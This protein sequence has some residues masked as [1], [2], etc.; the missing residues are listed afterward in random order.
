MISISQAYIIGFVIGDGNLSKI[1]FLIRMYDRD[2]EYVNSILVPFFNKA[3]NKKPKT[4]Y[5]SHNR[6]YVVY[7]NSKEVWTFLH[8]L[9]IPFGSKSRTVRVPQAINNS[10]LENKKAFLAALFDA[11]G[12]IGRIV[13]KKRH[14]KGYIYFQLKTVNPTLIEQCATLLEETMGFRPRIYHYSYGS[15]LRINGPKQV[16]RIL[17]SLKVLHPRF[18][19]ILA[20]K[21]H[22]PGSV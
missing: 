12:S 14:P 18:L 10:S 7:K 8:N 20:D 17:K 6:G 15:I 1:D 3:F 9:G 5:D 19:P 16:V 22:G 21:K 11:E 4:I 2:K 13:D